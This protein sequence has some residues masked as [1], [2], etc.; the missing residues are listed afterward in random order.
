M[1]VPFSIIKF[2]AVLFL[3][4]VPLAQPAKA[5]SY[6]KPG[7]RFAPD[8]QTIDLG[9]RQ[10]RICDG[11]FQLNNGSGDELFLTISRN[12]SHVAPILQK[13][14]KM[15]FLWGRLTQADQD[16]SSRI[17]QVQVIMDTYIGDIY[18]SGAAYKFYSND[19][20]KPA[21]V[22]KFSNGTVPYGM[23]VYAPTSTS[24]VQPHFLS[25]RGDLK[26]APRKQYNCFIYVRFDA[27][28][29]LYLFSRLLWDPE[30]SKNDPFDFDNLHTYIEALTALF[31]SLEVS[32]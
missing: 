1:A 18:L 4:A 31:A 17:E 28:N 12:S 7:D 6:C 16:F 14:E 19:E 32:P 11:R 24:T 25:C 30:V 23:L 27:A 20:L 10:F 2:L 8:G 5:E 26:G 3:I 22:E 21:E 29:D 15:D 9:G 13:F